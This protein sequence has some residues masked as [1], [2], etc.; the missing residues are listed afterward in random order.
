[1][2]KAAAKN[3]NATAVPAVSVRSLKNTGKFT[4]GMPRTK[5]EKEAMEAAFCSECPKDLSKEVRD[6][7]SEL[8]Q[9]A[10][11]NIMLKVAPYMAPSVCAMRMVESSQIPALGGV[12]KYWRM[13]YR[14]DLVVHCKR[15]ELEAFLVHE[16]LHLISCHHD[17]AQTK[18]VTLDDMYLAN[19]AE[20]ISINQNVAALKMTLPP[21]GVIPESYNLPVN[22]IWEEYFDMLK[23]AVETHKIELP[24]LMDQGSGSDGQSHSHECGKSGDGDSEGEGGDPVFKDRT[25]VGTGVTGVEAEVIRKETAEKIKDHQKANGIGSVPANLAVWADQQLAPAE[26]PWERELCAMLKGELTRGKADYSYAKLHRRQAMYP[27]RIPA[28]VAYKPRVALLVDTSGSMTCGDYL[29]R[30][31]NEVQGVIKALQGSVQLV[32]CDYNVSSAEKIFNAK[33]AKLTGGGG[34]DMTN[35][36]EWILDNIRPA[37]DFVVTLTDGYTAWPDTFKLRHIAVVLSDDGDLPP[38]GKSIRALG[39]NNKKKGKR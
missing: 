6:R 14:P 20:D 1:M 25:I 17:R 35:G 15:E 3:A 36:L 27:I 21:G 4:E 32:C 16:A 5:E 31:M 28:M 23:P 26:V 24:R 19:I 2:A 10:R 34:T 11:Y 13:Y 30:A 22:L 8:L 18:G 33:A 12:D 39:N 29:D 37:P 7:A 9:A 38:F